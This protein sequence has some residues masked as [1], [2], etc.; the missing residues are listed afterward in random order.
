[1]E[2][3]KNIKKLRTEKGLHQEQLAE[4]MGVSTASVSKWETGQSAPELT[5]LAELADFFE[6]SIDALLG[7]S[8]GGHRIDTLL[9][10]ME[11]LENEGNYS[12]AQAIAEK[13]MQAYPNSV[14]II[15]K[16]ANLYYRVYSYTRDQLAMERSIDLTKKLLMLEKDSSG[17]RKFEL[18]SNLGN[19]YAILQNGELA[20]KYYLEGNVG[21]MNDR[22]LAG[23]LAKEGEN[24][25]AI[26]AV[27]EVFVDSLYQ[28][29]TDALQ[30]ADCWEKI[31][32]PQK[33]HA[34]LSWAYRTLNMFSGK[35]TAYLSSLK[36]TFLTQL[37][38]FAEE[39]GDRYDAESYIQKAVCAAQDC[40]CDGVEEDFLVCGKSRK[41][42][43]NTLSSIAEIH[44]YL[45]SM[46]VKRLC[47][48]VNE[49]SK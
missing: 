28:L 23:I 36:V 44:Q 38:K 40:N 19:Q 17:A 35:S 33:A 5:L 1:M 30:L 16:C 48:F 3:G 12:E 32:E 42:L 22:A 34:A 13:T 21:G 6:V 26:V 41:L 11:R 7:H 18:L 8:I 39:N 49:K 45:E 46:G 2:L 24:Q 4:A 31:G 29:L 37:A 9:S 10:T 47:A 14:A 15:Q 43:G 25:K 27:S 20:R